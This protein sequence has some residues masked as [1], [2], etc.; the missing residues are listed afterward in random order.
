MKIIISLI[1]F[2]TTTLLTLPTMAAD[3]YVKLEPPSNSVPGTVADPFNSLSEAYDYVVNKNGGAGGYYFDISGQTFWTEVDINGYVL[4]VAGNVN[5]GGDY[6][7]IAAGGTLTQ[8]VDKT[9]SAP[10]LAAMT[11]IDRVR[12][13]ASAGFGA[14]FEMYSTASVVINDIKAYTTLANQN[15]GGNWQLIAGDDY[16]G[17]S[18][19]CAGTDSA[20]SH[21][22]FHACGD[23]GKLHWLQGSHSKETVSWDNGSAAELSVWVRSAVVA[24]S[25]CSGLDWG[26][27]CRDLGFVIASKASNGDTVHVSGGEYRATTTIALSNKSIMLIGG[28]N[29]DT[30]VLDPNSHPT[31]ISGDI[32]AN[33]QNGINDHG[34]A[35][36]INGVTLD[37]SC[38]QGNNKDRLF[39]V[40]DSNVRL[41]N[42]TI[43]GFQLTTAHAHGPVM[44]F[45]SNSSS[46]TAEFDNVSMIGN[47]GREIGAVLV[48]NAGGDAQFTIDHSLIEG[49]RGDNG[50]AFGTAGY[51]SIVVNSSTFRNN[52]AI[53][54]DNSV[55]QD[56]NSHMVGQG[57]AIQ[58]GAGILAINH[59]VFESNTA[60]GGGNGGA[61]ATAGTAVTINN[62]TFSHN[63]TDVD[64]SGL[65]SGNGG[66]IYASGGIF[67]LYD[68]TIKYNVARFSG[69]VGLEG[70]VVADIQ[71]SLFDGNLA[72]NHGGG[73][74][75]KSNATVTLNN[76]TFVANRSGSIGGGLAIEQSQAIVEYN[77]FY[78]NLANSG[79]GI[80]LWYNA[81]SSVSM[82]SNILLDNTANEGSNFFW[83]SQSEGV[84]DNG[85]NMVGRNSDVGIGGNGVN[86]ALTTA[87]NGPGS[88]S[89]ADS[90]VTGHV[91]ET[92]L[93]NN[94]GPTLTLGLVVGSPAIDIDGACSLIV[95]QRG[96]PRG[97]TGCDIGAYEFNMLLDGDD[98][99]DG[100]KNVADNCPTVKN[101]VGVSNVDGITPLNDN[102]S[103]LDLDGIGD[104]CDLDIDGDGVA[105]DLGGETGLD[106]FSR[107]SVG[108][109]TD[110]DNDGI[111]DTCNTACGLAG[112]VA[113]DND[114]GDAFPDLS[115]NCPLIS[116]ADQ[117]D[118]DADGEG[119]ICDSDDDGDTIPDVVDNCPAKSNIDQA[120]E[121]FDSIG[122]ICE[123]VFV[124]RM[125]DGGLASGD[126]STW[127]TAC[128]DINYA[129]TQANSLS[130]NQ[131]FIRKG[132]Y[133]IANTI[134][135]QRGIALIGGFAGGEYR[136][137][138]SNSAM[139]ITIL[140]GDDSATAIV[141][142]L[143]LKSGGFSPLLKANATGTDA[144]SEILLSNLII[145]AAGSINSLNGAGL[146]INDSWVSLE[147]M[148][149]IANE[150]LNGAAISLTNNAI[151][152]V[153]SSDFSGNSAKHSGAA[154]YANNYALLNINAS[155]FSGNNTVVSSGGGGAAVYANGSNKAININQ[156][157]FS[158]NVSANDGGA[159]LF[160]NI[161]AT[162]NVSANHFNANM[163]NNGLGGA[164][165]LTGVASG[166]LSV[167]RSSFVENEANSGGA[168]AHD[169]NSSPTGILNSTFA[170]NQANNNGGALALSKNS[171]MIEYSSFVGNLASV[172]GGAIHTS[173][174]LT[175]QRSL[176][177]GNIATGGGNNVN[178][179]FI[180]TGFNLIG[181]DSDA[182]VYPIEVY[183]PAVNGSFT[184]SLTA[185]SAI[186]STAP[187]FDS[188]D[189][190]SGATITQTLSLTEDS[191][192]RDAMTLAECGASAIDQRGQPRQDDATGM[193]DIG[194][195][196][197]TDFTCQQ[198][199][200]A[201]R[202][203]GN[204]YLANC[205]P[206]KEYI[207]DF[208]SLG[209]GSVHYYYL[210]LLSA[211]LLIR[212]LQHR[213]G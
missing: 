91:F 32:D 85:F 127:E 176:L 89:L 153:E 106:G 194:A 169:A 209:G 45:Q 40:H 46:H 163:A 57:G 123:S 96:E 200:Q 208:G 92:V 119:D 157:Q 86:I 189:D 103:D 201:I 77:T 8:A 58:M 55:A 116:S 197:Y 16:R 10:M 21:A 130:I 82:R 3:F 36:K 53:L 44:H 71:R 35:C 204:Y 68:S 182:G 63:M 88:F 142:D 164:I 41:K 70:A 206:D 156:T 213:K 129:I 28:Y 107:I 152:K 5:V 110:T 203:S 38:I 74:H 51:V 195:F 175:I 113:D 61:I 2:L 180:D 20:L 115:D 42:I 84:V 185:V 125:A 147:N 161:A 27:A 22:V 39:S 160:N 190:I 93:S 101:G 149:F 212:P 83:Y 98:D 174:S 186:V 114:D 148:Q 112:M 47:D 56:G 11:D 172:D 33:D 109:H 19:T 198:E 117:S 151:L 138:Q 168:I 177:L 87:F 150:A 162:I 25:T 6:S 15:S 170:N 4:V 76:S 97:D 52:D 48:Y 13:Y 12:V 210:M 144:S 79:G 165:A 137:S 136:V 102:Q 205:A 173:T 37:H 184:S 133:H 140:S 132:V 146:M 159:L 181:Y 54:E 94:G 121:D 139:N 7:Q 166:Y 31:I 202:N 78:N 120:D 34:G 66:A 141:T 23:G 131:V 128:Y 187:S 67:N 100:V 104:A 75:L 50:G 158:G 207:L 1:C 193:C 69:G 59:S 81:T 9:L 135:L 118:A 192:A 43:T 95:D 26:N 24:Q 64:M 72:G 188:S 49:N 30:G 178:G 199:S 60:T 134:D 111:P 105:N 62:S 65:G 108:T 191:E 143:T 167:Q 126:C 171:H 145:N 211:L 90:I 183:D 73:L 29:A 155:D 17:V 99:D 14:G 179:L 18:A 124:K 122:D 80:G 196:E 154:I